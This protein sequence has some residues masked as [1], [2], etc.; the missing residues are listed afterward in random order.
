MSEHTAA[1]PLPRTPLI[2][3]EQELAALSAL[4]RDEAVPLVTVTG[5]GGVGKTRLALQVTANVAASFA[6]GVAFVPLADLRD[7]RLLLPTL[8][9]ALALDAT[10]AGSAQER[11]LA[12]L[13]PR[14]YLLVLDNLEQITDAAPDLGN[15]LAL[16]PGLTILATSREVLRLSGEHVV[17]INPLPVPEAVQLFVTRAKAADA[18][19]GITAANAATIA[20]IC[21]RLDGLP[22]AIELAVARLRSLPPATLLAHLD[23]ALPLLTEGARDQ[24]HRLRTMRAAIAW[25]YELLEPEE[26]RLFRRLSVFIGGFDLHGAAAVVGDDRGGGVS[27]G[28]AGATLNLLNGITSLV[29]KS[30]LQV[31]PDMDGNA[32]RYRMLET[33]RE[34]GNEQLRSTGEEERARQAVAV[35]ILSLA[36]YVR[37]RRVSPEVAALHARL[38]LEYD[39]VRAV[40]SWAIK[41]EDAELGLA[42][43]CA[44][45]AFWMTRG[46]YQEGHDWLAQALR[47]SGHA[48]PGLLGD[49]MALIGWLAYLLGDISESRSWLTQALA[50]AREAEDRYTEA[51]TL[52]SLALVAAQQGDLAEAARWSD[53]S[54][55]GF[56]AITETPGPQLASMARANRGQI[57]LI[58]GDLDITARLVEEA[59]VSQQELGFA[60][61]LGDTL[62]IA[63]DLAVRQGDFGLAWSR[64]RES[65]DQA[66]THEDKRHLAETYVAIGILAMVCGD[67]AR[68]ARYF[69]AASALR[70]STGAAMSSWT[71]PSYQ[72]AEVA[73]RGALA[74]DVFEANWAVGEGWSLDEAIVDAATMTVDGARGREQLTPDAVAAFN[75]TPREVEVLRLLATGMSDR[76]IGETLFVGTRTVNYHVANLLAKLELDS[77]VA[78]TAFAVRHGLG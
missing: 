56:A 55:A 49:A 3:R 20:A 48:P 26:Q 15:L 21:R 63:G 64:Y 68:A 70:G 14:Q 28:D 50:A 31:M 45:R 67:P 18:A 33:V 27:S 35:Y 51:S 37:E 25:S 42:L 57:A 8:V 75:L 58:Q 74:L 52:L 59:R 23:Q 62:R 9:R 6:D 43:S 69:G 17:P 47:L 73:A 72:R 2:G 32:P 34:F 10:D 12:Y 11:L 71:Q 41:R 46:Y 16:C 29:E 36:Q 5:P 1:L 65:L 40:L 30:L 44:M 19:F 60:W 4:V 39:N 22:L 38:D 54:I 61:A 53:A 76:E 78:A 7:P 13:G 24:P 66:K 77:R